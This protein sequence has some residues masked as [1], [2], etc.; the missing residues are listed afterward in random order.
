MSSDEGF[1]V[2]WFSRAIGKPLNLPFCDAL[3]TLMNENF[4]FWLIYPF[5]LS[6]KS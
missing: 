6:N 4:R 3:A 2:T 1:N 5:Q